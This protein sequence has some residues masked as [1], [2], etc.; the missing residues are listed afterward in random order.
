[1]TAFFIF[2]HVI[3]CIFL[4]IIILMQSGRGGGLTESFAQAGEMFGARTNE[5]LVR[6]T[7]ILAC[8]FFVTCLGLAL[9]S[10]QKGKSL[11]TTQ[12]VSMPAPAPVPLPS[13]EVPLGEVPQAPVDEVPQVPAVT[14]AIE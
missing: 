10:A 1:M 11:M 7:T 5:M 14:G 3:V 13:E 9:L 2:I 8:L 6:T 12:A 4:G